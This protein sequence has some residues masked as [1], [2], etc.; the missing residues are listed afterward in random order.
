MQIAVWKTHPWKCTV[1]AMGAMSNGYWTRIHPRDTGIW[2]WSQ[3]TVHCFVLPHCS[4]SK[5]I[6]G[7]GGIWVQF[8]N[9]PQDAL[10]IV[11]HA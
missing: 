5:A 7:G 1:T 2:S 10:I 3:I 11:T 4:A 6:G 8:K 9:D